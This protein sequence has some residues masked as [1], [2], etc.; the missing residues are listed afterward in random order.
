MARLGLRPELAG[1]CAGGRLSKFEASSVLPLPL[2][3]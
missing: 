2:H 3:R 1:Y